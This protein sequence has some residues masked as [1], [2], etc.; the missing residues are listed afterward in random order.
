MK[1]LERMPRV[2]RSNVLGTL[3]DDSGELSRELGIRL[4]RMGTEMP[5][6]GVSEPMEGMKDYHVRVE[7]VQTSVENPFKSLEDGSSELQKLFDGQV[8]SFEAVVK[9]WNPLEGVM[10]GDGA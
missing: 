7:C 1:G 2:I 3:L 4:V 5:W 10:V 8:F 6:N 9:L